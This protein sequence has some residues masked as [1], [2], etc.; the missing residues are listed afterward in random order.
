MIAKIRFSAEYGF[1]NDFLNSILRHNIS[2]YSVHLTD[3][4]FTAVCYAKDYESVARLARRFQCRVRIK[5]KKGLYFLFRPYRKRKGILAGVVV[6]PL[7]CFFLSCVIWKIEINTDDRQLKNILAHS[8]YNQGVYPGNICSKDKLTDVQ[9]RLMLENKNLGYIT[10]N[11]YKGILTCEVYSRNEKQNNKSDYSRNDIY[12]R[13]T[14]VVTDIRV[15]SGFSRVQLGQ[16]VTR[17]DVLV[18]SARTDDKGRLDI[19]DT[20]AYI[21]GDCEKEYRIFVPYNKTVHLYTGSQRKNVT[22]SFMG[23]EFKIEENDLSDYTLYTTRRAITPAGL[24]GF[25]FPFTIKTDTFSQLEERQIQY[26][27][28][29]AVKAGE[30]QIRHMIN[31]DTRLL[32]EY[33]ARYDYTLSDG[34][35][36]VVCI[37][38]GH[39]IM[40]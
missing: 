26:D 33:S 38:K 17:G 21:A 24:F 40:T 9:R 39:Y 10:L 19:R 13:L 4:G 30:N 34:G 36:T 5:E 16:S 23:R 6:F 20:A 25:S 7:L 11:F 14:G 8:L 32:E 22:V 29:E 28:T 37:V 27:F 12:S 35:V 31:N 1:F 2:V 18:T 3:F 15:Y